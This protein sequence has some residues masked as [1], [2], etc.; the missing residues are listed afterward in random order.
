M[1]LGDCKMDLYESIFVRKSVRSYAHTPLD[2]KV[3]LDIDGFIAQV[4]TLISG[5]QIHFD[6]S[7]RS[8]AFSTAKAPYY[9]NIFCPPHEFDLENIGFIWEFVSLYLTSQGIGSC[10]LG[11]KNFFLEDRGPYPYAVTLAFGMANG[12]PYRTYEEF[13]R[14]P[15]DEISSGEDPR[16][17]AARLAPS[18]LNV[19]AWFYACHGG[20]IDVYRKTAFHYSASMFL[21]IARISMGVG[22]AHLYIASHALNMPFEFVMHASAPDKPGYEYIGT[23]CET[24]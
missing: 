3:L 13:N 18:G 7:S 11:M 24:R 20:V 21:R 12:S 6:I 9:I 10:F 16:I 2:E 17:E 5:S 4:P 8:R 14:K 22:L 15:L 23:I 19:Q 1:Q